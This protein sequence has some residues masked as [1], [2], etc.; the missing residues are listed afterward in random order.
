MSYRERLVRSCEEVIE[1][2]ESFYTGLNEDPRLL[3]RLSSVKAWYYIP[4]IDAVGPRKFIGYRNISADFYL[5]HTGKSAEATFP[6]S[7][8]LDGGATE[9][10]LKKWFEITGPGTAKHK[11][12]SEKTDELLAR[13]GKK[14]CSISRYCVPIGFRLAA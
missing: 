7:K 14:P 11:Y 4:K 13:W 5:A 12:V 3:T 6:R 9:R 10:V 2:T 8:R 1:S